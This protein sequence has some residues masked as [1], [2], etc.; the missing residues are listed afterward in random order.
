MCRRFGPVTDGGVR[1]AVPLL[2]MDG[3]Y[4]TARGGWCSP[5]WSPP[6]AS[7]SVENMRGWIV[8]GLTTGVIFGGAAA[9][10]AWIFAMPL[11]ITVR[12][13]ALAVPL[14]IVLE[15]IA[16]RARGVQFPLAFLAI[17]V[18]GVLLFLQVRDVSAGPRFV[19]RAD[20][21]AAATARGTSGSSSGVRRGGAAARTPA[22]GPTTRVIEPRRAESEGD[23]SAASAGNEPATLVLHNPTDATLR[24]WIVDSGGRSRLGRLRAGRS[25]E[26]SVRVREPSVVI[27]VRG[28]AGG[29]AMPVGVS[30]GATIRVALVSAAEPL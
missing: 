14:G 2:I 11:G 9:M 25:R 23:R 21:P 7:P 10:V 17:G 27:E 26:V 3:K 20:D 18:L 12:V 28:P 6:A 15:W 1:I 5:H 19:R 16:V 30:P 22:A 24:L 29:Y 4:N 13:V 8:V